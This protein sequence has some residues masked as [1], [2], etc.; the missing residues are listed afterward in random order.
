MRNQKNLSEIFFMKGNQRSKYIFS[1]FYFTSE[2]DVFHIITREED[3]SVIS[4]QKQLHF[5]FSKMQV[6][7]LR[8]AP[9]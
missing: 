2:A 7:K 3:I 9:V 8:N 6:I 1:N 5:L 4:E